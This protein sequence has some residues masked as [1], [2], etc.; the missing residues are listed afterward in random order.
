MLLEAEKSRDQEV[1]SEKAFLLHY[2]MVKGLGVG[3]DH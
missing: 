2:P 1:V 3:S